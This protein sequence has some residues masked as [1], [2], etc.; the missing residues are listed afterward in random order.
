MGSVQGEVTVTDT[1]LLQ[2]TESACSERS[3][4]LRITHVVVPQEEREPRRSS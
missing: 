1:V 2:V 3:K 4:R